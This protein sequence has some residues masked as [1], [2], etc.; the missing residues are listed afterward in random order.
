MLETDTAFQTTTIIKGLSSNL[1]YSL[2][3]FSLVFS[4]RYVPSH[5]LLWMII[6]SW[7]SLYLH[8]SFGTLLIHHEALG[9]Y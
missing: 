1:S 8:I 7:F 6:V 4:P 5:D 2:L 3:W 9:K